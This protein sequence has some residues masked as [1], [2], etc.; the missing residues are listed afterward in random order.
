MSVVAR[1]KEKKVFQR[2]INWVKSCPKA[3]LNED[4]EMAKGFS[5]RVISGKHSISEVV[6]MNVQ[7]G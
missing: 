6:D 1:F 7:L 2:G 3:V 4:R 5:K